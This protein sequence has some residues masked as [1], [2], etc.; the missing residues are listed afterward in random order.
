MDAD[1]TDAPHE[2]SIAGVVW[3]RLKIIPAL[4]GP[5]L[6]MVSKGSPLLHSLEKGF[7]ELYFSEVEPGAVKAWKRHRRQTQLFAVPAGKIKIAM[8]DARE[9]SPTFGQSMLLKL[10]RPD[11]Y[12]LLRIPPGIWYG[13]EAISA[14]PALICNL[15]DLPHDPLESDRLDVNDP[16]APLRWE[17]LDFSE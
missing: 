6:K 1:L 8:L 9:D 2:T 13:F 14:R 16:Q 15:A 10:G 17:R 11:H 7:G 12:R 3:Q 4:G 5:V